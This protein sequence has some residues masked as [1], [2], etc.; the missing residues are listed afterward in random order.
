MLNIGRIKIATIGAYQ[1][2]L[3]RVA[4]LEDEGYKRYLGLMSFL[5]ESAEPPTEKTGADYSTPGPQTYE[6][7][8]GY[9]QEQRSRGGLGISKGYAQWFRNLLSSYFPGGFF[10][11]PKK[12][13]GMF[14][15]KEIYDMTGD[16]YEI[17]ADDFESVLPKMM[18]QKINK[19]Q[20][21]DFKVSEIKFD[22]ELIRTV[23]AKAIEYFN[24]HPEEIK[25]GLV[26]AYSGQFEDETDEEET[27]K[28]KGS[29]LGVAQAFFRPRID[30]ARFEE[31]LKKS[32]AT[33]E[34]PEARRG[35]VDRGVL[36][37]LEK[38]LTAEKPIKWRWV[39]VDG[40]MLTF[41][42]PELEGD[43]KFTIKLPRD[44]GG[45]RSGEYSMRVR[46]V[47]GSGAIVEFV[48]QKRDIQRRYEGQVRSLGMGVDQLKKFI[49][50]GF[51]FRYRNVLFAKPLSELI[52]EFSG[53]IVISGKRIGDVEDLATAS[54]SGEDITE[55]RGTEDTEEA[56]EKLR[57]EEEEKAKSVSRRWWSSPEL[58][59][60]FLSIEPSDSAR[61]VKVVSDQ[62][63]VESDK[64]VISLDSI[65]AT[66]PVV[67]FVMQT[68]LDPTTPM[69]VANADPWM[70]ITINH[71]RRDAVREPVLLRQF[72]ELMEVT[73][74]RKEKKTTTPTKS[75]VITPTAPVTPEIPETP[76]APVAPA[77]TGP[78]VPSSVET[79][80]ADSSTDAPIPV[81]EVQA[82]INSLSEGSLR[83]SLSR[84][85]QDLQETIMSLKGEP[86]L[87]KF[88]RRKKQFN[89]YL[90]RQVI[91]F[92]SELLYISELP[93]D[94]L[95][96]KSQA[97]KI[98]VL[99]ADELPVIDSET[100]EGQ[101]EV[102]R[103]IKAF[104]TRTVKKMEQPGLSMMASTLSPE[105][106]QRVMVRA[107]HQVTSGQSVQ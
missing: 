1:S 32:D 35:S 97:K 20:G 9:R 4:A 63:P 54:E 80:E 2:F 37:K 14:G 46:R 72:F 105:L 75:K 47:S 69:G 67:N 19:D 98:G 88:F 40:D 28:K 50:N 34:E 5:G 85:K 74:T 13:G 55:A 51:V 17:A 68:I 10:S 41:T 90:V 59:K 99:D 64:N 84:L 95:Y 7:E 56:R 12:T 33:G 15:S 94:D 89:D 52:T 60:R 101:K 39:G 70:T 49:E 21:I 8:L 23:V 29:K 11:D 30:D 107:Y 71:L 48:D 106:M 76:L 100:P 103:Q 65:I 31:S 87:D 27:D 92:V 78:S 26:R 82:Y 61:I 83:S 36:D 79:R 57:R 93:P 77:V 86:A 22:R 42:L 104:I 3:T 102:D 25:K 45:I 24:D 91:P 73:Q 43:R 38:A 6:E 53:Q 96:R 58:Q 81:A 16:F 62:Y 66:R 18:S 44:I